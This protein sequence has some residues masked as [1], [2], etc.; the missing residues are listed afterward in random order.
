M[1]LVIGIADYRFTWQ[2]LHQVQ[3]IIPWV[4]FE[5][6]MCMFAALY[7]PLQNHTGK[8]ILMCLLVALHFQ[9]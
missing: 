3:S 5:F 2:V 6:P 9:V 4:L 1:G 8:G 7:D